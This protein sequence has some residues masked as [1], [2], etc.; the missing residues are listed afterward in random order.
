MFICPAIKHYKELWRFEDRTRSGHLKSVRP[1]AAIKTYSSAFAEIRSGN[2]IMSWKLI[3]ST[4]SGR[5]SS[6]MTYIRAHLRSKGHLLIPALKEIQRTRTKRLLQ[7]HAENGKKTSSSRGRKCSPP[8][9]SITTRT[10]RFMLKRPFRCIL[11]MQKAIT[12]LHNGLVGCPTRGW[13]LFIFV[14]KVW[15]LMPLLSRVCATRSCRTS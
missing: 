1:E 14:T 9:S 10:T 11:R 6:G 2:K 4:H 15:K 7:W 12:F 8:R 3:I 13:H 5:A